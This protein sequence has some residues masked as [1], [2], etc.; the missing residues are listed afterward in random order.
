M[1]PENKLLLTLAPMPPAGGVPCHSI[2]AVQGNGDPALGNDGVVEYKSAHLDYAASEFVVRSGHSCQGNPRTIEE[3]RRI[4]LEH[5]AR[6]DAASSPPAD[7]T[8]P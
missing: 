1:S 2:I 8:K 6:V 5:I 3:V 7:A 4:L